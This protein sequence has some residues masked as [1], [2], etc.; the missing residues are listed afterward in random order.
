MVPTI[1]L[2]SVL[3][4][5]LHRFLPGDILLMM[6]GELGDDDSDLERV[7]SCWA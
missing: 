3:V 1:F 7:R 5:L 4:F 6:V 2:I